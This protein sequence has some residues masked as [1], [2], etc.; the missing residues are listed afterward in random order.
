[1]TLLCTG[2]TILSLFVITNV[3]CSCCFI[4]VCVG[5]SERIRPYVS[6][7]CA[8]AGCFCGILSVSAYGAGSWWDPNDKS[9]SLAYGVW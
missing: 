3:L 6:E 1:M 5:L 8:M 2:Y 9:T 7:T 4:P